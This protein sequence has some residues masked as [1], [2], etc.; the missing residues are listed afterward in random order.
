MTNALFA[1]QTGITRKLDPQR[2]RKYCVRWLQIRDEVVAGK[3]QSASL[4]AARALSGVA[5]SMGEMA[6]ATAEVVDNSIQSLATSMTA[7][8]MNYARGELRKGVKEIA[9]EEHNP[10][11]MKYIRSC[12]DLYATEN[13]RKY[14]EREGEEGVKWCSAFVNWCIGQSGI[15]GTNSARALSWASWGDPCPE[16]KVGAIV[17]TK[18]TKYRH[19]AFVE[20][21]D[22]KYMMLGGNQT[23]ANGKG[24]YDQV[25]I[26]PINKNIVVGYRWPK[27]A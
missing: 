10:D 19:V 5:A 22:G 27:D 25:S 11:I 1:K 14:T 6:A 9:G 24:G 23:Q 17:V 26:R 15:Q 8:W 20:W 7:P 2:D 16:P 21:S 12:P 18:G 4:S 13:K 3:H